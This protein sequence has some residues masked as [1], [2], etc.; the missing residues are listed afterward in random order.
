M[1]TITKSNKDNFLIWQKVNGT[2]SLADLQADGLPPVFVPGV[3]NFIITIKTDNTGSSNDDQF[4][5]PTTGTGYNYGVDWGDSNTD[6]GQTGNIT[7]TY[8]VAG[9]YTV[10]IS[11]DFPRIFFSNGGDRLK[12]LTIENWGNNK[13]VSMANAFFGC[14]NLVGNYT[15]SPD[16]S[17]V[18]D[19]SFMFANCAAFNQ[20]VAFST[21]AVTTMASMFNGCQAFNK[22]VAFDTSLVTDMSFMFATCPA[23]NQS[24][25][26]STGAVTTMA[27]MFNGCT[28]FNQALALSTSVVT[29]MSSMFLNCMVFNQSLTFNTISVTTMKEMFRGCTAFNQP[30]VFATGAVTD[31]T[32]M[33]QD[34]TVF[35]KGISGFNIALVTDMTN[36]LNGTTLSTANYDAL[37]IAWEGQ[38]E[39]TS[40]TFH[41]GNA[42]FT[43]AT[44][45][46]ETAR[47]VLIN[48]SSWSITDGG[49]TA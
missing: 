28:A 5:I 32:S 3:T 6:T 25:A 39:Q 27:S 19:M 34:C 31:M 10:S 13:W 49:P 16:T 7:H 11:G 15:D 40:V 24:V 48:T 21:G 4:T 33:F 30:V 37:L 23:F 12:L 22:A 44:S 2:L 29:N 38:V 14:A 1:A 35:N 47:G 18:T 17:L 20:S 41:G 43:K 42:L 9:T 36:M 8:S 46:A 26:F 45:P